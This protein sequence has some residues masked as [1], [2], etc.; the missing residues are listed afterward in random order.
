[1]ISF[2]QALKERK[3]RLTPEDA[4][5]I[6]LSRIEKID[7]RGRPY[8]R[9]HKPTK[10]GMI[11]VKRGDVLIS[12]I[13][14]DK[15]AMCVFDEAD[16]AAAT[17]HYSAYEVD[18]SYASPEFLGWF[19]KSRY[20]QKALAE[21]VGGG[22]K[23]EIKAKKFLSINIP[24][25]DRDVQ[26]KIVEK[27]NTLE[28]KASELSALERENLKLAAQL[29]KLILMQTIGLPKG[30]NW[31]PNEP[32]A[33]SDDWEWKPLADLL[34]DKPRNGY[35]PPAVIHKTN[36]KTLKLAAT[37]SGKFKPSEFKYIA[38]DIPG[39]SYL[40]LEP[41]DIL[42]QRSNSIDY[43]GVSAIYDG[44]P[45]EFIYPDLMMKLRPTDEILP[46][47]LHLVLSSP[48]IRAYFKNSASGTSG[49][50]PKIN[51]KIVMAAMIPVPPIDQ[52]LQTIERART[53]L[54]EID[55]LIKVF[56]QQ[57]QL[58]PSLIESSIT[59]LLSKDW[60]VTVAPSPAQNLSF[61]IQQCAAALLN[62]GFNKGEMAIAKVLYLL[63]EIYGL[64]IGIQFTRQNFGPYDSAVKVAL[65]SGLSKKNK[66]FIKSG[67]Q[68]KEFYRLQPNGQKILKYQ[69]SQ[70]ADDFL[71]DLLPKLGR[72]Q[73]I[74]IE[75]LASVCKVIQD[76]K[77]VKE[78]EVQRYMAEW[79]PNKFTPD[80][81][82]K[83]LK[84][85]LSQGWDKK[86]L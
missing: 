29:E 8:L 36:T 15:G 48:F 26:D 43:V 54:S 70:Q 4:N 9:D 20:F 81:I 86:L 18:T 35:S 30:E 16:E 55:E 64:P 2:T 6:R 60:P 13:N 25:P 34:I 46:E 14:A 80:Q 73:S 11:T 5:N 83:S 84:F 79:K 7:F 63:Q 23:T 62:K 50:M 27:L 32:F 42:I 69:L 76:N 75:R 24:I 78:A 61:S 40:W 10:T 82:S 22:I 41:G 19:L 56:N 59:K 77:T 68:A 74:D 85:I 37:T 51:Q 3:E 58:V 17:I 67:K 45:H 38:E 21:Q 1:M 28:A 49:N 39:D 44:G 12:G 57:V 33:L 71:D 31:L 53:M 65:T 72:A 47:Y 66:F 52:Q